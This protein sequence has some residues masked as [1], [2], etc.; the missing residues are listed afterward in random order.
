MT[1]RILE[2]GASESESNPEWVSRFRIGARHS[3]DVSGRQNFGTIIFV[4]RNA[5]AVGLW[6]FTQ[7]A[8]ATPLRKFLDQKIAT[9]GTPLRRQ[10]WTISVGFGGLPP[11]NYEKPRKFK[12]QPQ[13]QQ[14]SLVTKW[15]PQARHTLSGLKDHSAGFIDRGT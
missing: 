13:P 2:R 15:Q 11:Q 9:A 4:N 3:G 1:R 6:H 5:T 14:P 8:E 10:Q 7:A 12:R